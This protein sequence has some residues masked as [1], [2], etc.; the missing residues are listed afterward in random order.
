M[1]ALTSFTIGW[2]GICLSFWLD[3]P[4]MAGFSGFFIVTALGPMVYPTFNI[5]VGEVC[6]RDFVVIAS[7]IMEVGNLTASLTLPVV[8]NKNNPQEVFKFGTLAFACINILGLLVVFFYFIE[9]KDLTKREIFDKIRGRSVGMGEKG[10][11]EKIIIPA[12]HEEDEDN[13]PDPRVLKKDWR[14]RFNAKGLM[15]HRLF[16]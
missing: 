15:N 1:V 16:R 5:Y 10:R 4:V 9:T 11:K 2:T 13:S 7:F 3:I 12:E 8:F 6:P 14:F